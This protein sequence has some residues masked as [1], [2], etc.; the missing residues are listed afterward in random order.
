METIY[1]RVAGLDIHKKTIV[2]CLRTTRPDGSVQE[3]IRT[4]GTM[5]DDLLALGDWLSEHHVTHAAMESTGVLWKPIWNILE[6]YDLQLQLVNA[7]ELKQVP[8]RKSDVRDCQWIAHLLACGLLN[9]SFVPER[10]QR[11]LRDL[12]RHRAQLHGEHTRCVNRIHKVLQDAN[13]KLSSVATNILGKSGRDMLAALVLGQDDPNSM[14][15]LAR[16]KLRKKIPELKRALKGHVLDHHQFMLEQ[17]LDHL[18]LLEEQI[19]RFNDRIEE[20]LR[21]FVD[22]ETFNALDAVPG[23]NRITIE[24]V[25]AEIGVDMA[26]FPSSQALASW[27]GVCPGN[28]ESAGKRKRRRTTKGN[29]WLRRA[30]CEAAWSAG[31][32]R[33]TYFNAQYRRLASRRGK[34]RAIMAVAHSLLV[35]FYHLLKSEHPQYQELGGNHFDTLDPM[36]LRRHLVKRLESLGY[37]VTLAERKAA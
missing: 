30:L 13:I 11:Q 9:S 18:G 37:E 7:R 25:V 3:E 31:R 33:E 5:T 34:K 35:V 8:G 2:V 20:A 23:V 6:G 22:D 27:A 16:G 26:Q 17:L 1:D 29:V 14:A 21:P 4:V 10:G 12:T 24:N 19:S 32:S 15:E 36:R 28:E